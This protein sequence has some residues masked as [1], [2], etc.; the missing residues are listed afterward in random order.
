MALTE[1]TTLNEILIRV[2]A[3]GTWAAHQ[4]HL[5]EI[6]DGADVK[7]ANYLD[8]TPLVAEDVAEILGPVIADVMAQRDALQAQVAELRAQVAALETPDAPP[9]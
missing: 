6:V 4:R 5:Y 8:P 9:G 7:S 2:A 3:D 1:R